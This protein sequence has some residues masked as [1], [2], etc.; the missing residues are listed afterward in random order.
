MHP[1]KV[2][3]TPIEFDNFRTGFLDELGLRVQTPKE[4]HRKVALHC[5]SLL[6]DVGLRVDGQE[7]DRIRKGMCFDLPSFLTPTDLTSPSLVLWVAFIA[8]LAMNST[9]LRCDMG[10]FPSNVAL[11]SLQNSRLN[12]PRS[13]PFGRFLAQEVQIIGRLSGQ[14][15]C[16]D[17]FS[18]SHAPPTTR[19]L[20]NNPKKSPLGVV[21]HRGGVGG[22]YC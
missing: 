18:L 9:A 12:P 16:N 5:L 1:L 11:H 21:Y 8:M 17:G 10:R 14:A 2:S 7:L 19:I 3:S 20:I 15:H 6:E 22:G 13:V 4:G